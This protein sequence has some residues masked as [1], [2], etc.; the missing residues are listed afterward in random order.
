MSDNK[1]NTE[2]INGEIFQTI[3]KN[4]F[5]INELRKT[6]YE[7]ME[8]IG[9]TIEKEVKIILR[10]LITSITTRNFYA[11]IL[12]EM[13]RNVPEHSE[14]EKIELTIYK[15]NNKIAF[16]VKDNG[17]GIMDSLNTNPAYNI[18]NDQ[19]AL[20]FAIRPGISRSYK[21]DPNRDSVW[22]NSGFGL[23]MVSNIMKKIGYFQLCSGEYTVKIK[24]EFNNNDF[25][26]NKK[27]KGTEVVVII[28]EDVKINIP[29]TLK[30]ISQK[31][32]EEAKERKFAPY[33]NIK[34]ASQAS[35]LI[36][37]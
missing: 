1:I 16:K 37:E 14:A 32:S 6:S 25:Y 5:I 10:E 19:T 30:N 36:E 27:I 21:R 15:T 18:G 7:N 29:E 23:Y 8:Y 22:Q 13:M 33:A 2:V 20:S 3:Y 11:Y 26:K 24:G 31:G 4:T 17:I 28:N 35:T 12:R 9:E 34:T